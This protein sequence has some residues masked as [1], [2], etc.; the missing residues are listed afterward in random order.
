MIENLMLNNSKWTSVNGG[1][2]LQIWDHVR[3]EVMLDVYH[4]MASMLVGKEM[5][6]FEY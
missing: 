1:A 2:E 5:E 4:I 6:K 3:G